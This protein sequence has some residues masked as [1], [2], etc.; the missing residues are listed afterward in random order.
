MIYHAAA[1][2]GIQFRPDRQAADLF[3]GFRGQNTVDLFELFAQGLPDPFP[4]RGVLI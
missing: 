2:I 4:E 1:R 3:L